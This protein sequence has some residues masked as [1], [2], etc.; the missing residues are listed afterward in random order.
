[1]NIPVQLTA[2][3]HL[4]M[5]VA[6]IHEIRDDLRLRKHGSVRARIRTSI[7][8]HRKLSLAGCNASRRE[9]GLAPYRTFRAMR[10]AMQDFRHRRPAAQ[11]LALAA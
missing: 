10:E 4:V 7:A 6:L 11:P 1:M 8:L 2:S 3:E 5:L 9:V